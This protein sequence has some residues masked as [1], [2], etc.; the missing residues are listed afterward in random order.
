MEPPSALA[1]VKDGACEILGAVA[2]PAD[3][4]E[5][6]GR[7]AGDR[8]GE[9]HAPRHVHRRR[10]RPQVEARLHRRG[11]AA[12]EGSRRAGQGDLDARRR[13][14]PRLLPH[15]HRAAHGRRARRR[16]QGDRVAAPVRVSVDHG[17][18]WSRPRRRRRI[19]VPDGRLRHRVG[20]AQRAGGVDGRQGPR[21]RRLVSLGLQHPARLRRVFLR[22]RT[23]ARGEEGSRRC[24]SRS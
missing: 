8:P 6:S 14:P 22:R 10:V 13:D 7:R 16:R 15:R 11:R 24:S 12:V 4:A 23:G 9:G 19:R 20:R 1:S 21:A 2:G 18:V 5:G 17:A 3:G